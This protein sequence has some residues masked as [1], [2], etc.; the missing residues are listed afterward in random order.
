MKLLLVLLA[1]LAGVWLWR[2]GRRDMPQSRRP[3]QPTGPTVQDMV[4]CPTCGVHLPRSDAV[5]GRRGH[6]C[7]AAHRTQ[8]E[9]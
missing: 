7:C 6:Y 9:D 1:V 5:A 4:R 8:A 2:S 3:A